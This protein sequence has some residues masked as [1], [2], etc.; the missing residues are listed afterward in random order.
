MG[1]RGRGGG[2]GG[3]GGGVKRAATGKGGKQEL[4]ALDKTLHGVGR[5]CM[6]NKFTRLFLF[7]YI[8]L[9]HLVLFLTLHN[10]SHSH[11]LAHLHHPKTSVALD[12]AKFLGGN[13]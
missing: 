6:M 9:I 12:K 13:D 8:A 1:V 10:W 11:H 4:N 3:G 5:L 7:G 2:G